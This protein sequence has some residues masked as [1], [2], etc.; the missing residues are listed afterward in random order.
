MYRIFPWRMIKLFLDFYSILY[1][2]AMCQ[3]NYDATNIGQPEI[4][5]GLIY[6]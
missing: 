2:Y 1:R 4:S 5:N 3:I 6:I